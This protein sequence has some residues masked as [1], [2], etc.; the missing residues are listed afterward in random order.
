MRVRA[1]ST[2]QV[3]NNKLIMKTF[4][5]LQVGDN[6]LKI[7]FKFHY[8]DGLSNIFRVSRVTAIEKDPNIDCLYN[9]WTK[10]MQFD[11]EDLYL[12]DHCV[13]FG[14]DT[15]EIYSTSVFL[16][17]FQFVFRVIPKYILY[18]LDKLL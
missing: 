13:V 8:I 2:L 16:G 10:E 14:S 17:I 1:S 18:L 6:V 12:D 9:F 7:F 15:I 3:I 5:D 11:I 4:N